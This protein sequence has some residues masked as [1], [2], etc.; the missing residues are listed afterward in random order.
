MYDVI[1]VGARV[2][3]APTAMLLARQGYRVLLVDKSLFPSDILS[4]TLLIWPPGI[5]LLQHWGLLELL[6]ATQCPPLTRYRASLGAPFDP[7]LPSGSMGPPRRWK[8]AARRMPHGARSWISSW[9]MPQLGLG[10]RCMKAS[11]STRSSWKGSVS[12][13]FA[14]R[15]R[16]GA[17]HGTGHPGHRRRW[18]EFSRSA[19]RLCG[20]VPDARSY[21]P[22]LL[23]V[24]A[25]CRPGGQC[26]RGIL[27]PGLVRCLCLADT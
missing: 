2:A 1:V 8:G 22:H 3:G 14:G 21:C 12:W 26:A 18:G 6:Q 10:S 13:A 16:R 24:L 17:S 4:S 19:D 15:P 27:S 9:S 25:G 7:T 20:R 23:C 5:A 11:R